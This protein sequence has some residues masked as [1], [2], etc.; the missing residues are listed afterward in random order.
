ML[1][2]L[3]LLLSIVVAACGGGDSPSQPQPLSLGAMTPSTVNVTLT[4]EQAA[5]RYQTSVGASYTGSASGTVYVRVEDPDG[6]F[7]AAYPAISD[8]RA[9]LTL[10]I[11]GAPAPGRY[12]RPVTIRVCPDAACSREFPGSPQTLQKDL[13]IESL[14]VDKRSLSFSGPVG[15]GAAAQSLAITLPQGKSYDYSSHYVQY[16][17]PTGGTSLQLPSAVFDITRT[18]SGLQLKPR[19]AAAGS[20][21]WQMQLNSPGYRSQ[22]VNVAYEV[23]G[24]PVGPVT[25][26]ADTLSVT[27][28]GGEVFGDVDAAVN[29]NFTETRIT[30][31][32]N[33]DP[34]QTGWLLFYTA[35]PLT[36]GAGPAGNGQR[37]RFKFSRCGYGGAIA[38]L[39]TGTYSA[40]VRIDVSAYGQTWAYTVPTTLTVR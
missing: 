23:S 37:W 17:S 18:A 29:M 40:T 39:T 32:G 36:L 16:T 27:L 30:I 3:S 28:T 21:S 31:T 25:L 26:L 13:R 8:T 22:T 9:S 4:D 6:V 12:T 35:E 33:P 19:G 7:T 34:S 38:C 2:R 20:Y 24:T 5:S 10:E 14:G 15:L 11:G 1:R